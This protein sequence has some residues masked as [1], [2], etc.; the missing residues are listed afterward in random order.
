MIRF[1]SI[2]F[3][4]FVLGCATGRQTA[5]NKTGGGSFE[6]DTHKMVTG[7]PHKHGESGCSHET[8]EEE[9]Q[10]LYKHDGQWHYDHFGHYDHK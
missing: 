6:A 4:I 7:H 8:K 10:T 1:I 3:A 9:G 2:V 5:G